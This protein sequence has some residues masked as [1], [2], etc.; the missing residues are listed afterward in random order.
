M[1]ALMCPLKKRLGPDKIING[2]HADFQITRAEVSDFG[3][4]SSETLF[5]RDGPGVD[6]EVGCDNP[7]L[8][9]PGSAK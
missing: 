8:W 5:Y 2:S 7:R 6:L 3:D 1:S 9:V 4:V